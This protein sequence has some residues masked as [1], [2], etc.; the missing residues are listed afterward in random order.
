MNKLKISAPM[1]AMIVLAILSA[2]LHLEAGIRI[3]DS[4]GS[5]AEIDAKTTKTVATIEYMSQHY[6]LPMIYFVLL[7]GIQFWIEMRHY[8]SWAELATTGF[9]AAPVV[10]YMV[11]CLFILAKLPS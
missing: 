7:I 2:Y 6:W 5:F 11:S 10:A 1:Q 9:L 3:E 4:S 8:P